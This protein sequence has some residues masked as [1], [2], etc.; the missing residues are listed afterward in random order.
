MCACV[1]S[2]LIHVF[3][4]L[5]TLCH[6]MDCIPLGSSIHGILQTILEWVAMAPPRDLPYLEMELRDKTH[7]SYVSC[8]GRW[9]LYH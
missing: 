2:H 1:L 9:V 5:W 6:P 3:A 8:I 7:I 4:T